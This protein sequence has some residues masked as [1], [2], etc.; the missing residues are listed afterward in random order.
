MILSAVEFIAISGEK[1]VYLKGTFAAGFMALVGYLFILSGWFLLF[2]MG[3]RLIMGRMDYVFGQKRTRQLI[4]DAGDG[5]RLPSDAIKAVGKVTGI[6][7]TIVVVICLV[8]CLS[9]KGLAE[10]MPEITVPLLSSM[11]Q[12]SVD[13][14]I[15]A[16]GVGI[17]LAVYLRISRIQLEIQLGLRSPRRHKHRFRHRRP[18]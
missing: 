6:L 16:A 13:S 2:Y 18:R 11:I 8:F 15:V 1:A 4:Q 14:M 9:Q 17:I 3:N 5:K 7:D 10:A 12:A